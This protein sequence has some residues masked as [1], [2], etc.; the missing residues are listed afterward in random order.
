M[1][2]SST[3]VIPPSPTALS[4]SNDTYLFFLFLSL[5]SSNKRA[6]TVAG[7]TTLACLLLASQVFTAY[8]VFNQKQQIHSLQK[9]S[10][11][12]GKQ[13]TRSSQGKKGTLKSL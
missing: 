10:E 8:M 1:F 9:N 2:F 5:R 3:L 6:L 12:M 7:L 4:S 13:L 11:R